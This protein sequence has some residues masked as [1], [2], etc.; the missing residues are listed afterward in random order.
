MKTLKWNEMIKKIIK[1]SKTQGF[2]YKQALEILIEVEKF[3]VER[4]MRR[5]EDNK[6]IIL[7]KAYAALERKLQNQTSI[8]SSSNSQFSFTYQTNKYA[9]F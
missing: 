4:D 3:I 1:K 7:Q 2:T 8:P 5:K 9:A 6:L